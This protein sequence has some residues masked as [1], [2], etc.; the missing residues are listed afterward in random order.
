MTNTPLLTVP[1]RVLRGSLFLDEMFGLGWKCRVNL[2]HF[3]I[4]DC[5]L[6]VLGQL[7]PGGYEGAC[8]EYDLTE[9][10]AWKLG[11]TA[12][13]TSPDQIRDES[14]ELTREWRRVIVVIE[15][16]GRAA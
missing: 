16:E 1:D 3:V 14:A 2:H 8:K 15:K 6:C 13:S 5:W 9:L 4:R 7:H 12:A 10:E 11:F